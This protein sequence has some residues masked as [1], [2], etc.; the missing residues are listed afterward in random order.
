IVWLRE[1]VR[2]WDMVSDGDLDGLAEVIK[3][4]SRGVVHYEPPAGVIRQLGGPPW[5]E[6]AA[7]QR[8]HFKGYDLLRGQPWLRVSIPEGDLVRPA[9]QFVYELVNAELTRNVSPVLAWDAAR[10]R[11]LL[12]ELPHNLLGAIYLQ[13]AEAIRSNRLSRRCQVCRR[14]FELAPG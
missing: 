4:E 2:V 7:D 5:S 11:T 6:V 14:W 9:L 12:P 3:W 13:L 1:A 8:R 10:N